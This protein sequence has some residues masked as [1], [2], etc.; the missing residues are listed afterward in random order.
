MPAWRAK[1]RCRRELSARHPAGVPRARLGNAGLCLRHRRRL[2]RS[3]L[4]RAGHHLPCAGKGRL[5]RGHAAAAG[6]AFLR[7]L[8]ALWPPAPRLS[9]HRRGHR[10]DGQPLHRG[11]KAPR[12]RR[13]F[14][15]RQG[16]HAP[17]PR[18]H[19][20]RQPHPSGLRQCAD[21]ARRRG[22]VAAPLCPLR[23]LGRPRAQFLP[24][25]RG[26][27][28]AVVR[29]G[30]KVH[31]PRRQMAGGGPSHRGYARSRHL[32]D[33]LRAARG[34]ARAARHGGSRR[35]PRRLRPRLQNA[36][37]RTGPRARPRALPE[38]RQALPSAKPAGHAPFAA[39]TGRRLR[40]AL[41]AR[42]A[43]HVRQGRR[44]AR[45]CRGQVLHRPRA[46]LLRG[47]QLLRPHLPSGAHR[48][49]AQ[50]GVRPPRGEIAGAL[51]R[52]QG[53]HPR[54]RRPHG[55]LPPARLQGPARAR[56]L[57]GQTVPLPQAL[58]KPRRQ[59]PRICGHPPRTA[60][61]SRGEEGVRA[62]RRAL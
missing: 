4:L 59:P 27:G 16:G 13:I 10:L 14:P 37:R 58:Q 42:L 55:Q 54:C 34:G 15:R 60:R 41:R 35:R 2:R 24:R 18:H 22:G 36:V 1:R 7:G 33:G 29:H 26:R 32:R 49:L 38:A 56:S 39:G 19:R 20:L 57:Q 46:R 47:L 45:A 52:F 21:P 40:P 23:L 8:S 17:G 31:P 62:L 12:P 9:R 25:G 30:R 28:R 3:P 5:P 44:R 11:E 6:L 43:P 53:L 50:Q 61:G 51:A 48:H